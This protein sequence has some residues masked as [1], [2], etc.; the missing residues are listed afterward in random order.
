MVDS[1]GFDEASVLAFVNKLHYDN[2]QKTKFS[3]AEIAEAMD[4]E[5]IAAAK[6]DPGTIVVW[7]ESLNNILKRLG[8]DGKLTVITEPDDNDVECAAVV[9]PGLA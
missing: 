4:P 1:P 7:T 5:Q 3:L 8:V 2:P 6:A 9:F